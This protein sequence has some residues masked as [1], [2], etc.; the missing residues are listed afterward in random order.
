MVSL[1]YAVVERER[2]FLVAAIPHGV[3]EVWEIEDRYVDGAR[4]RL[5]EVR[6]PDGSVQRKVGHNV[7]LGEGPAEVACT[8][9]Y[10]DDA[11]WSLLADRLPTRR[12]RKRRHHVHRDGLHVVVDE[13]EDGTL[14]AEIDDG[15]A[16]PVAVPDW[17]EV[18]SDV[19]ADEAWTGAAL[20]ATRDRTA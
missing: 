8:S 13:L 7:R 1:K 15:D 9:L 12:L 14:V 4:L 20:A 10:L 6:K 19:S 17:L 16:T 2:R 11:E 3:S 18:V 5:R